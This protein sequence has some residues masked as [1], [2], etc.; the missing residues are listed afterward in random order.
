MGPV[1]LKDNTH[2]PIEDVAT[3][4][5][6]SNVQKKVLGHAFPTFRIGVDKRD[7]LAKF[8]AIY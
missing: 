1:S 8:N 2:T 7:D 6:L 3:G 5:K 4:Q